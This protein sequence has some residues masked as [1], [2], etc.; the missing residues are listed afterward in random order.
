MKEEVKY[1]VPEFFRVWRKTIARESVPELTLYLSALSN[2]KLLL[3]DS[4]VTT[5]VNG[6][7]VILPNKQKGLD[8]TEVSTVEGVTPPKQG[9]VRKLINCKVISM[10]TN[11]GESNS[12][13]TERIEI[14]YEMQPERKGMD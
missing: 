6:Q 9:T 4:P 8:Y 10:E 11:L 12:D 2:G 5:W 3:S 13:E 14:V 1:D 7:L